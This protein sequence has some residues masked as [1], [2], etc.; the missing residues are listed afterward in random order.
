M[1]L[2]QRDGMGQSHAL[3]TWAPQPGGRWVGEVGRIEARRNQDLDIVV[4]QLTPALL[5]LLQ[6]EQMQLPCC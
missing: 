4:L 3:L 6:S 1:T 5:T 2:H